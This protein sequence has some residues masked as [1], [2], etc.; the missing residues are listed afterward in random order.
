LRNSNRLITEFLPSLGRKIEI[1]L[2]RYAPKAQAIDEEHITKALTRPAQWR[3]P[4]DA[5]AVQRMHSAT[6][7]L[8][9]E[10]SAVSKVVLQMAKAACGVEAAPQEKRR[11]GLFRSRDN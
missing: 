1:V 2:N 6:R 11:F 4:A 7:P 3:V 8:A 5:V 10:K 9:E